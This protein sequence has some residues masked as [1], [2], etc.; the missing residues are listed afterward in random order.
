M[1]QCLFLRWG[2]QAVIGV[3]ALMADQLGIQFKAITLSTIC[4]EC[5]VPIPSF[6]GLEITD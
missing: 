1:T 6:G 4:Q 3:A 2:W 5:F